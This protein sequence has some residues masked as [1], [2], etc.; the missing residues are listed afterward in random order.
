[1]LDPLTS[2]ER[3][4]RSLGGYRQHFMNELCLD[5]VT[6]LVCEAR[7]LD[8][9]LLSLENRAARK[10]FVFHSIHLR[11]GSD[12]VR[13]G[14]RA[15]LGRLAEA[16]ALVVLTPQQRD[17]LVERFGFGDRIHVIPH[18]I[19][20]AGGAG[21]RSA[22]GPGGGVTDMSADG[23]AGGVTDT[24]VDGP[25]GRTDDRPAGEAAGGTAAAT[26]QPGKVVVVS[27]LSPE[28]DVAA[29][30]EAFAMVH[31]VIPNARL[32][33]WGSGPLESD[34]RALAERLGLDGVV[35]FR[36]YTQNAN[37]VFQSAE[38]SLVTSKWEGF[39][40]AVMESLANG[41]PVVAYDVKYGPA[42]MI[43]DGIN[44][45]LVEPGDRAALA[46][47]VIGLL[48]APDW[49][50][51]AMPEQAI[52]QMEDFSEDKLAQRWDHLFG[53]LVNPVARRP[54]PLKRLWRRVPAGPRNAIARALRL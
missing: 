36:G 12:V 20:T 1:V 23:S 47:R 13:S 6:H 14:N 44:G 28:K 38:C 2:A 49:Q 42:A 31:Q 41:T 11:P 22:G 34:L 18:A 17:D 19:E 26:R 29:A 52:R 9:D 46:D 33:V 27:R 53:S 15:L 40:L 54:G 25:A 3:T 7:L 16:D 48:S 21:D 50:K 8:H 51:A 5:P 35:R 37:S 10:I 30:V 45:H 39:S 32:E 24:S 43:R 4:F